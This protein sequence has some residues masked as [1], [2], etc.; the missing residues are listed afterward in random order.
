MSASA[1][2]VADSVG[3]GN[4]TNMYMIVGFE[5]TA[6]CSLERQPGQTPKDVS[7]SEYS[8]A[9]PTPQQIKTGVPQTE[10]M[11]QLCCA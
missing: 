5:V 7:C 3:L 10:S 1:A 9:A 11:L 6:V 4:N 2:A 8:T